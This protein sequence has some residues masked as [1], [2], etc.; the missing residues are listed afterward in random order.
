MK[1][2]ILTIL[3]I[4]LFTLVLCG[5]AQATNNTHN[6]D[7][8]NQNI[9][10]TSISVSTS[11]VPGT[12]SS[13]TTSSWVDYQT[14]QM[15]NPVLIDIWVDPM[16][17]NDQNSGNSASQ[18]LR[19]LSQAWYN[20]PSSQ[21]ISTT[22]Y[23]IK[24]MPGNYDENYLP[25][26]GWMESRYG[27]Y[28]CPIII[29]SAYSTGG[30]NIQTNDIINFYNC[31]YIYLI[32]LN[33][34]SNANNVLHLEKCDHILLKNLNITGLGSISDYS[35]PQED[36]KA[37]QC[38]NIYVE[39]CDISN[40]WNV[41]V[42]FVAVES[43][44][45]L[46]NKIHQA[47]D[48]CIYLKGGS[49]HFIIS[50]NEIYDAGNGGF[51]AGQGTGFEWMMPPYLHYEA[52]D[53][54]FVN[55]IIHDT[56]GAGMGVNGG[57]N[58]LLAYN[59]LYRVGEISHALE[60]V[61]GI[62]GGGDVNKCLYY[63]SIGGWGTS[64]SG[65][66][67]RI[68]NKNVYVYNNIIY[69]PE[70]YQSQWS[71]FAVAEPYTPSTSSNIPSPSRA[72]DNLQIKGNII[73]NGPSNLPLGIENINTSLNSSQLRSENLINIIKPQ[74]IDPENGNFRPV[75]GGNVYNI[76]S[77]TIPDFP[78]NDYPTS[79][80]V[81]AGNLGNSIDKDYDLN[82]RGA[83]GPPGAFAQPTV[84]NPLKVDSTN[85]A[86]GATGVSINT[87]LTINFS[88]NIQA[89]T[90]FNNIY[91]KNM[92]SG[93]LLS[94][95]GK[96]ISG[97]VLTINYTNLLKNNTTYKVYL[98]ASAV[99]DL[100]GVGISSSYTFTFT[101]MTAAKDI[102]PPFVKTTTPAPGATGIS[103]TTPITINFSENIQAGDKFTGIYIKNLTTGKIV[104]LGSKT[105]NGSTLTLKMTSSR[106]RKNIYQVYIPA[107]A[108]KDGSGNN[109]AS[110]YLFQFKT[111]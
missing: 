76:A 21:V 33:L 87:P 83:N 100:T 101:T 69:N 7:N 44:Y 40:A 36:L 39:N 91:L 108:V 16:N 18:A 99:K 85:P 12:T 86:N 64:I 20:I 57:Y 46:G 26:N 77:Y 107:A 102:T 35:A 5:A 24:L 94:L 4:P 65:D 37:N 75:N 31:R 109:L 60:F 23:C 93:S 103:F 49:S 25:S 43:G 71:Q 38:Q 30:V 82:T 48:W 62:R 28:N 90:N 1:K 70:G 79:P 32:G 78:G 73:W 61:H 15:G 66:E 96:I 8:I 3:L 81:N 42:D 74:L 2:F 106:L 97:N 19:T 54:K 95:S 110:A 34:R 58:I 45:I 47:G 53:I 104:S 14:Y 59:T 72:D 50:N 17:G 11:S 41:P 105:I 88:K 52:Y 63:L 13:V 68:P 51:T 27:T 9:S 22:G 111:A 80:L 56:R 6:Q 10:T 98:P 89:G 55:N 84:I 92:I 67:Q 29:Q